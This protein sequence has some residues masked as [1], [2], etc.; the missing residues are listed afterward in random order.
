MANIAICS[1]VLHAGKD[2]ITVTWALNESFPA[3]TAANY[4]SVEVL[5]CYAP[6]SQIDRKW[7]K[8]NVDLKKDKT[9]QS[10][11]VKQPYATSSGKYEYL[12]DREV[13]SASYFVR[14]YALDASDTQVL[15]KL[16]FL[17]L[18]FLVGKLWEN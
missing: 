3:S 17:A 18:G 12:V 14:A 1:S 2:M 8:T 5:L 4:K 9:C 15:N 13:P 11:I 16:I 7:R 10:K 6:I